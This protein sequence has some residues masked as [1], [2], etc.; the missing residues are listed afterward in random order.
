M[1]IQ[2]RINAL[3]WTALCER[4]NQHGAALTPPLLTA[5]ECAELISLYPND[6]LFRSHIVMARYRFGSGDYKYFSYPLP[7]IVEELRS[8]FYPSLAKVANDWNGKLGIDES[9]PAEHKDF[10][11]Q[12]H[13]VG[14]VRP[15]PLLLHYEVGDYNCLHQ[16]I[17]GKIAFPLQLTC[18]L[19]PKEA[20]EG[21]EFVL[22][23]QRPRAQ[24]VPR[25]IVPEQGQV[26]L[27]TTRSRPV[28]GKR[29]YFRVAVR[30]GVSPIRDGVRYTLGTPFHD[31]E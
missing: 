16:D 6:K 25:V 20:Y 9:Y 21:G 2:Q 14:Q 28:S 18:F 19:S 29:G 17:Y 1:D 13:A 26:L 8:G 12:C 24:S 15:T 11:K 22:V 5:S 4:L 30:H 3:D 27:F 7:P 10:L 23:E 31:A